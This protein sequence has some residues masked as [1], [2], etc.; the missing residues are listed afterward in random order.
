M[1]DISPNTEFQVVYELGEFWS[2]NKR[3]KSMC[4][5]N[6]NLTW[7]SIWPDVIT[8][9]PTTEPTMEPTFEPTTEPTA[10]PTAEPTLE[11]IV[12]LTDVDSDDTESAFVSDHILQSVREWS[13]NRA[14]GPT[15][16][17]IVGVVMMLWLRS[18]AMSARKEKMR[19]MVMYGAIDT[20]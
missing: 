12:G 15:L 11:P 10:E 7:W 14:M 13:A 1:Y 3:L 20:V 5:D 9:D 16:F 17:V 4:A 2:E 6:L 8:D 18:C 19:G